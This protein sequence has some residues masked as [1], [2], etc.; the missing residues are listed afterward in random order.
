MHPCSPAAK[1]RK[2]RHL[3]W[4]RASVLIAWQ[5]R[6]LVK[7]RQAQAGSFA[8]QPFGWFAFQRK[9]SVSEDRIGIFLQKDKDLFGR[10]SR[11]LPICIT[12]RS[13]GGRDETGHDFSTGDVHAP[14]S[15]VKSYAM[16]PLFIFRRKW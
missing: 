10:Q 1:K 11:L 2:A 14:I 16:I 5:P 15:F 8:S 6:F 3:N 4:K 13:I 9:W 12:K 7:I